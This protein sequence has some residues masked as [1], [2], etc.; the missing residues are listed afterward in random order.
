MRS[1]TALLFSLCCAITAFPAL[2]H[3]QFQAPAKDELEM[4]SDPKA[5]GADAVYFYR[6]EKTD[7]NLHYHSYYVRIKVLTEKGKEL[8][9]VRTPYERRSFKV[10]DVQG[11]TIHR[12]GSVFPLTTKPS[13]LTDVKTKNYQANTV[14][15]TLPNVE[16]GSIL[17]YRLQLRYDDNTVSSPTW[18]VQQ[19]YYVH[20][21]HYLFIPSSGSGYITNGRGELLNRLMYA[22]VGGIAK[23]VVRQIDGRYLLDVSDTPAIPAEDWMPP[24]NSLNMRLQFYYTQYYSVGEFWQKEGNR[25]AKETDRFANPS[26]TLK[27]AVSHIVTPT[28]TDDQKARKLYAEVMKLDNTS[29]TREKSNAERKSDKL[30]DI[31]DAE[32]V[33]T[34]KSG[35][36]DDI[37]LLYMA[38]ARAAGIRAYPLQ[39]VNRNRAIFDPSYLSTSQLDD[40]LVAVDINGKEILLDPGQKYC[41][42]GLIHWKHSLASGFRVSDKGVAPVST[43]GAPYVASVVQR[44]ADLDID[45]NGGVK[46]TVRVVMKGQQALHW[47]QLSLQNDEDEVKKQ[48]NEAVRAYMPDG[49]E[50]DFTHF[51]GLTDYDSNLMAVVSISGNLATTTGKHVFLPELFFESHAGHPFVAQDKRTTPIDVHYPGMEQDDVTYHLPAEFT[52]ENP[53]APAQFSWP[54]NAVFKTATTVKGTD[55]NVFRVVGFNFTVL[56]PKDYGELHDFYQKVA[57]ADQQQLVLTRSQV[58]KGTDHEVSVQKQ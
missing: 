11:R 47:R 33:W 53:P 51:L 24:L 43:P 48:F 29:F 38:L 44:I 7:D 50:A 57:A 25:W 6:E 35:S 36:S 3:A 28:D 39:V 19:P 58:A 54:N 4:T 23:D 5:P 15:F 34:Q 18:D 10:T 12:D 26:K 2:L 46:G 13:D 1:R 14:V 30:K 41:P 9:T 17:E 56:D 8:A 45:S 32:D 20:K 40:Y 49:V 27:E 37:A 55:V 31:R 42:Y 52:V 16:V 22:S 21:A